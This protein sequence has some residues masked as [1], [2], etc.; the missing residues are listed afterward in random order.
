MNIQEKLEYYKNQRIGLRKQNL[1]GSWMEIIQYNNAEDLTV[2]FDTGYISRHKAFKEFRLG[3][4][5]DYLFPSKYGLGY[6]GIGKYK[7]GKEDRDIYNKWNSMFTR[8]YEASSDHNDFKYY[9]G[10]SVCEEWFNY[11]NFADWYTNNYYQI[12]NRRMCLDK[13][14]LK[15]KNKIYSPE[16]C[17]IVP[18]FINLLFGKLNT[19]KSK[20]L[21]IGVSKDANKYRAIIHIND[22]YHGLGFYDT[23]EEAFYVYKI[24]KENH[25]KEVADKYKTQLPQKVYDAMYAYEIEIDD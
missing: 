19:R 6:I 16:T 10:C 25:I 5:R 14:I 13:D 3:K 1:D 7:T 20:T 22:E 17:C 8:C 12:E 24:V 2:R 23:P 11:Q 15:K 9:M 4:I 21:P 18:D